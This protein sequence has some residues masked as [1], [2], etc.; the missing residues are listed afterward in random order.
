MP[1][2]NHCNFQGNKHGLYDPPAAVSPVNQLIAATT[3]TAALPFVPP[4]GKPS[5]A[6]PTA[7]Q[8]LPTSTANIAST[9][10]S[11]TKVLFNTAESDPRIIS[12]TKAT[13]I[14]PVPDAAIQMPGA[15]ISEEN[16][17]ASA[18]PTA[19]VQL[20]PVPNIAPTSPLLN[21]GAVASLAISAAPGG[22]AIIIG[23]QTITQG[24]DAVTISNVVISLG[25]LGLEVKSPAG[26]VTTVPVPPAEMLGKAM[27]T[28]GDKPGSTE[29]MSGGAQSVS[30]MPSRK[31]ILV[32]TEMAVYGLVIT[33]QDGKL[34]TITQSSRFAVTTKDRNPTSIT[35]STLPTS[36]TPLLLH[37]TTPTS[38]STPTTPTT[39]SLNPVASAVA[40]GL[41]NTTTGSSSQSSAAAMEKCSFLL[42][43]SSIAVL[44]VFSLIS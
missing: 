42:C 19:N 13:Q 39:T 41:Q 35:T 16:L 22:E 33:T 14:V 11:Q 34:T 24:G 32:T 38:F 36:I 40:K 20:F 27:A 18:N 15:P 6:S 9:K 44:L 5:A 26:V 28:L 2:Y 4:L 12:E 21:L 8:L 3:T 30:A 17:S 10:A 31:A 7:D 1:Y 43:K 37:P 25:G 23:S 29:S